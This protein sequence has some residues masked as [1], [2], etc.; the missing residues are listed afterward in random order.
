MMHKLRVRG[1]ERAEGE[2]FR[3]GREEERGKE[4]E[5]ASEGEKGA[6]DGEMAVDP[7]HESMA[8]NRGAA[9]CMLSTCSGATFF[10]AHRSAFLSSCARLRYA[11]GC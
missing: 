7:P 5:R 9:G 2:G 3:E 11:W 4:G 8:H 6:G 10:P 1:R